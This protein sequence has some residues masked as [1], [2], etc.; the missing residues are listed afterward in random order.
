MLRWQKGIGFVGSPGSGQW[1]GA[2]STNGGSGA[3]GAAALGV[4]GTIQSVGWSGDQRIDGELAGVKWQGGAVS[5][6]FPDGLDDYGYTE[7]GFAMLSA[8]QVKAVQETLDADAVDPFAAR[9]GFSVEG[10][11]DLVV[12]FAGLGSGDGTLRYANTTGA[13]TAYAYYPSTSINGGDIWYGPSGASPTVGNYDYHTI[14]HETGH[15]LGLKHGHETGV[16]GA[17]PYATNSM[18]YS[19]MTYNSYVGSDARYVYNETWGYAQTFMMYDIAALQYMYGADFETT[20]GDDVY[21]WDPATGTTTV[22]GVAALA[23]GGNRIFLTIWDGG[24]RDTYDL[25]RYATDLVVSLAPG[26]YSTFSAAQIAHLGNGHDARGN[27]FNALQYQGDPRSLI[28]DAIGG[29]GR[30]EISGNAAGNALSGG[31]GADTLAGLGGDDTLRGGDGPDSLSGGDGDDRLDG[32]NGTDRLDGGAGSDT[33]VYV[34]NTGSVRVDLAS[35]RVT[36]PGDGYKPETVTGVENAETGSGNDVFLGD[37]Q[38][39]R[40]YGNGGDD[41]FDGGGGNDYFDGGAGSDT[42]LYIANTTPVAVDLAGGVARFPGKPW[43]DEHFDRVENAS[44][45]SGADI[46]LGSGA[47]NVLKG[48]D[49]ADDL[50]GAGGADQ[51]IGGLGN[52]V[53]HFAEGDS[54]PGGRDTLI[55]GDGAAAFENPGK[56]A[57]DRIDI[58]AID[59]DATAAGDQAFVWGG[60]HGAGHLWASNAGKVTVI[61]GNTDGDALAEFEL[62]INDG[63]VRAGTYDAQDF[64]L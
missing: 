14:I 2:A 16:Y 40:F 33:V 19:V 60:G 53:F 10:F 44:T 34:E 41:T 52:D 49:G 39:N 11:T 32:G 46:L 50:T 21:A 31:K 29:S 58:S 27:V 22:D 28:E 59:A 15:A 48:G 30:D 4:P 37:G 23:P 25:S 18:E 20:A 63:G 51:L 7:P 17:L 26:G 38:P 5:Y 36:F 61:H 54:G 24:G 1:G 56:A 9:A 35:G 8:R 42:V 47:A 55:G 3:A 45:G 6:S 12:D 13:A 43:A 57:G 62:A 64:Y